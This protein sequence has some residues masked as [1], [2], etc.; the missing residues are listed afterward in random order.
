MLLFTRLHEAPLD[1]GQRAAAL[2][3]PLDHDTRVKSRFAIVLPEA[4]AV[5]ANLP[6]GTVLRDGAVLAGAHDRFALVVAAPQALVRVRCADALG[7]LRATYHLANRHVPVQLARDH[8][9]LE[10]DPVLERM[11]VA[12]GA[13]VEHVEAPFEPESGAYDAHRHHEGHHHREELDTVSA[14]LGEQLS[15]EAHRARTVAK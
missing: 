9:L 8:L 10:R 13:T 2:H 4:G 15:I 6:R 11:L 5:A 1:A 12:L 7:L 3:L 14:T